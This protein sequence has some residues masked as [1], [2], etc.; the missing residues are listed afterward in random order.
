MTT[1]LP[2]HSDHPP[3]ESEPSRLNER[4]RFVTDLTLHTDGGVTIIGYTRDVSLSGA[5]LFTDAP[6]TGITQGESGVAAITVQEGEHQY[7]MAF[8]CVVARVTPQGVGL[9]FDEPDDRSEEKAA[10][11][12][13]NGISESSEEEL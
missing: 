8:P 2:S 10:I 4:F 5:F 9:H 1:P 11:V 3:T 6:L 13:E 7:N 12:V